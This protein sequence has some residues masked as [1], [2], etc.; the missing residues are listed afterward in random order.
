[1]SSSVGLTTSSSNGSPR[2]AVGTTATRRRV[3][4]PSDLAE[5]LSDEEDNVTI[6]VHHH[7][8]IHLHHH[9]YQPVRYQ[10]AVLRRKFLMAVPEPVLHRIEDMLFWSV[11]AAEG[12]RSRRNVGRKILVLLIALVVLSLFVKLSFL[13]SYVHVHR[14]RVENGLLRLHTFK[15]DWA[16]AQRAVTENE[17]AH[18]PKPVVEKLSVSLSTAVWKFSL[19]TFSGH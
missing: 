1:M 2:H 11:G 13:S 15:D 19:S 7:N 9:H 16:Q 10:A 14:R 17:E 6:A 12:M 5:R 8:H 18:M 3:A 4:D